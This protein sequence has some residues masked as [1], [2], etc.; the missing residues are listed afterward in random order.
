MS[1]QTSS[2]VRPPRLTA[3]GCCAG[4]SSLCDAAQFRTPT[5]AQMPTAGGS[6]LLARTTAQSLF[7]APRLAK[8]A[9]DGVEIAAGMR[10]DGEQPGGRLCWGDGPPCTQG[11]GCLRRQIW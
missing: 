2:L 10:D 4:G 8:R 3:A 1:C 11:W 5:L 6:G 7:G 9:L